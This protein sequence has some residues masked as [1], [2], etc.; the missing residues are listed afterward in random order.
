MEKTLDLIFD[1]AIF[2]GGMLAGFLIYA[3]HH[4]EKF[5]LWEEKHIIA[6]LRR[7][8]Q[9]IKRF[10]RRCLKSNERFMAWLNK[11]Q[12]HGKPDTEF[13]QGQVK[14]FGDSWI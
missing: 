9:R 5:I 12:K 6:P 14:V 11:P 8:W 4:E 10:I 7:L 13:I 2:T 1:I 3:Y